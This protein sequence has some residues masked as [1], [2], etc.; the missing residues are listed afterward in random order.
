MPTIEQARGWYDDDDPVHGFGHVM[1]VLRLAE[2]IGEEMG[3][4]MAILRAA[5]LLHDVAEAHPGK[6]S[7]RVSH[8]QASAEFA[9][10]ILHEEGWP[11]ERIEAVMHCIRAHRFRGKEAPA[12]L[13][14]KIL[15]DADKLDVNGA[16]GAARTI[17]YA[18]QAEQPLF[19]EPSERFL[20]E[21]ETEPDEPHSAYHE[22][23][24]KLRRI[25]E[26]LHT[27]PAKRMGERRHEVLCSFF[28]QL[29]AEARGKG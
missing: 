16:F 17:G 2:K 3:A 25:Q 11:P 6:G 18:L 8:E 12:S 15:F 26:R 19:A 22:Y 20:Q 4:D 9:Q 23:L 14:A 13:E 21:G 28:E 24:F 1:R 27:E 29:A 7:K 10:R 5:A